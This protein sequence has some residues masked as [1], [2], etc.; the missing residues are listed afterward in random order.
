MNPP[1]EDVREILY[2]LSAR[3]AA[4]V[5]RRDLGLFLGVFDREASLTVYPW[6]AG[7]SD[8][9]RRMIGHGELG[10]VIELIGSYSRTFHLV[11]QGLY[12]VGHGE[13]TGE[14]YCV[15]HHFKSTGT[16]GADH[17]MYIRYEDQYRLGEGDGWKIAS[18]AVR[19]DWAE[20][21]EVPASC[22]PE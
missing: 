7:N 22:V 16:R 13:A 6:P 4:G 3:Y 9:S 17:V 20:D 8:A 11:G 18:R 5:D 15:A 21:R 12:G 14:V 19:V 2:S 10:R 1:T